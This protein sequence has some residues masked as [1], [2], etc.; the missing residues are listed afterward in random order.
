MSDDNAKQVVSK[1]ENTMRKVFIEKLVLNISIGDGADRLTRA[2][3]VLEELTGQNPVFS[4]A[5][6]TIRGFGIRRNQKTACRVTVRGAKAEK[7]LNLGLRVRDYELQAEN[8][9]DTGNFGFGVEEHIDLGLKYDPQV[10]IFG[11]DFYIVLARPGMRVSRRKHARAHIG[12]GHRVTKT[13]AQD[14]VKGKFQAVI[15]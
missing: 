7:I 10:G 15:L 13:D 8:F 2:G 3:K 12:Q 4:K 1:D 9:S 5:R 11:M 14:W 6:Y